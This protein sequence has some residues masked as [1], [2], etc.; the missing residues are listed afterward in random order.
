MTVCDVFQ[1]LLSAL[2]YDSKL[3]NAA[4]ATQRL[5]VIQVVS[6]W[7]H[8]LQHLQRRVSVAALEPGV[9]LADEA[10]H[11]FI[12]WSRAALIRSSVIQRHSIH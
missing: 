7:L 12:R 6:S 4:S 2:E 5:R 1:V 3:S 11:T 8:V 10:P 9:R